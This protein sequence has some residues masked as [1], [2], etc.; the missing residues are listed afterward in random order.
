MNRS[1]TVVA[2]AL[3]AGV[4][5]A[6][7]CGNRTRTPNRVEA[8]VVVTINGQVLPNALVTL[9]PT[10]AGFGGDAIATGVTD[11][12]GRAKL[13]CGGKPGACAG[14]NKVT[15]TEAPMPEEA[16]GE[17]AGSQAKAAQHQKGLKNRP[18]PPK[19]ASLAQSD[20]TLD[21]KK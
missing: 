19:Y 15:V 2:L 11:E 4:L 8:Q 6:A 12:S 18:I 16:R 20:A 14:T 1:G 3:A 7:G 9:T 10:E 13:T 21:I 17:D 5:A